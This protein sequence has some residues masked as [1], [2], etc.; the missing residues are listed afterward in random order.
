MKKQVTT[1]MLVVTF[2][3]ASFINSEATAQKKRAIQSGKS[4]AR[5]HQKVQQQRGQQR[6][7]V[8]PGFSQPTPKLG[9]QGQMLN[10]YGMKVVSVNWGSAAKRA[11]LEAGDVVTRINGRQIRSQWDYDQA[12]RSAA[13]N[14]Y[15][16]LQMKVRNIRFDWGYNVPKYA[17]VHATLDGYGGGV[18]PQSRPVVQAYSSK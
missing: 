1:M 3:S 7:Y 16:R 15:G 11:G 4:Q 17:Q 18:Y 9:F 5:V 10:G 12:L 2:L 14:N 8:D 13:N 6:V